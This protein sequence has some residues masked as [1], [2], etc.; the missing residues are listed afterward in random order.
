M[1]DLTGKRIVVTGGTRG[2]GLETVRLLAQQVAQVAFTGRTAQAVERALDQLGHPANVT[3]HACDVRDTAAMA[4]V[5]AEGCDVL[6]NNAA[7]GGG[8]ATLHETPPDEIAEC[9]EVNLIAAIQ[10]A[11]L[12]ITRMLESGGGTIINISSGLAMRAFPRMGNYCITK[13]GLNMATRAIDVEYRDSGIRTFGFQ[14]GV[15]DTDMQAGLQNSGL[16]R[17]MLPPA[18]KML[19]PEDPAQVIAFLCTSGADPFIGQELAI[20]SPE[21]QDAMGVSGKWVY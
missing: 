13:A 3:G 14:P 16:P 12:A 20:Y 4:A 9:I 8:F 2:V 17:E 19:P 10:T 18:D 21:L 5:I 15:V 11:Q 7:L 1:S 6:V